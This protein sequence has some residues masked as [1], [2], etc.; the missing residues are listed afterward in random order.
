[1]FTREKGHCA[2]EK[3][4]QYLT[5]QGLKLVTQNYYCKLGEI[6]LIMRDKDYLVFIEVRSRVSAEFGGGMVSITYAKRQK[7]I[8]SALHYLMIHKRQNKFA[9]RFDVISIDGVS[10][11]ITWIKNAF[12]IDY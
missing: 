12:G 6:D 8:K 4:L 11:A 7:I 10:A 1:M 2:E 9:V 3:A 5:T